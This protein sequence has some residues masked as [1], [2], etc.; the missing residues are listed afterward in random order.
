MHYHKVGRRVHHHACDFINFLICRRNIA[1]P[2][3]KKIRYLGPK[4]RMKN[5]LILVPEEHPKKRFYQPLPS[6]HHVTLA[7]IVQLPT[8]HMTLTYR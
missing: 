4:R 6:Y 3:I 7:C 1:V 2:V 5:A 8:L